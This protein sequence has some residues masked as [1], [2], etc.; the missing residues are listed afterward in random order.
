MG[1]IKKWIATE[2]EI[3]EGKTTDVYFVRTKECLDKDNLSDTKVWAEVTTGGIPREGKQFLFLGLYDVLNLFSKAN[4]DVNVY[5]IKEGTILPNNDIN[6]V[7]I[8]FLIVEGKYGD[9]SIYETPMLGYLCFQSGVGTAATRLR[10][11]AQDKTLLSFGIRRM[12]PEIAPTIDRACY[13]AGFDGISCVLSADKLGIPATGT[14]P[15]T[16]IMIEGGIAQAL[17]SFDKHVDSSVSRVALVDTF[18]DERVEVLQALEVLGDKLSGVRLD[19][20]SSRRGSFED[21]VQEIKWELKLRGRE[22]IKIFLS[23]G[24]TEDTVKK[25]RNFA[26][27]FGVGTFVSNSPTIDFAFDIV[28][29]KGKSIA[30]R[31]KFAGKKQVGFCDQCQTYL[32]EE[33]H[34]STIKCPSCGKSMDKMIDQVMGRGKILKAIPTELELRD[35][36]KNQLNEKLEI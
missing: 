5:S 25:Y 33:F 12:P 23:G 28:E 8:P 19:T 22:D 15:H 10:I 16:L 21:I 35:Y 17:Q 27:G 18:N 32:C 26:D 2:E 34:K 1:H 3:A 11:A 20:P 4:L 30:K 6:G 9:F 31:G 36:V 24:L 29:I 13:I 14:I 7:R